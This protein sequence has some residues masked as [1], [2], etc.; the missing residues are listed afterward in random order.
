ML[1]QLLAAAVAAMA[2]VLS[3]LGLAS[4][5]REGNLVGFR[6]AGGQRAYPS[7][8]LLALCSR[9]KRACVPWAYVDGIHSCVSTISPALPVCICAG[10][11][12]RR[13]CCTCCRP[14]VYW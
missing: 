8:T 4:L 5:R 14:V 2:P 1:S 11:S 9:E 12:T 3:M 7:R 10:N 13:P 6:A